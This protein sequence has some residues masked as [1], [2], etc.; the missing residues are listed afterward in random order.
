MESTQET[1]LS[2]SSSQANNESENKFTVTKRNLRDH[3]NVRSKSNLHESKYKRHSGGAIFLIEQTIKNSLHQ[4]QNQTKNL[5]KSNSLS[6]L[7]NDRFVNTSS[8]AKTVSQI[9]I[10]EPECNNTMLRSNND[11]SN[12]ETAITDN[13]TNSNNK[14]NSEEY[15]E[16]PSPSS[17]TNNSGI[18]LANIEDSYNDINDK[19]RLS[20]QSS[21]SCNTTVVSEVTLGTINFCDIS[22]RFNKEVDLTCLRVP[23]IGYEVMEERARFTVSNYDFVKRVDYNFSFGSSFSAYF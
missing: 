13:P 12:N 9:N 14:E 22:K 5:F 2:P 4:S 10:T 19:R 23:I 3:I 18:V 20:S 8:K 15:K 21:S 6:S 16:K 11:K 7:V 17:S 1:K